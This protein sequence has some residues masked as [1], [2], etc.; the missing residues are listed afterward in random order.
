MIILVDLALA[1]LVG[2][3]GAVVMTAFEYPFFRKWGMAGVTEWQVNWVMVSALHKKWKQL[4]TPI[5]SWTIASHLSHGIVAGIAF[6]LILP[7]LFTSLPF[8]RMS[9]VLD[10]VVFTVI[11]WFLFTFSGRGVYEATGEIRVTNRG[12]LGALLSGVVFGGVLGFLIPFT[13]Y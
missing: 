3:V 1:G 5:L 2:L 8:S 11:L 12:L 10:A 4:K 9:T 7:L 6:R 13:F